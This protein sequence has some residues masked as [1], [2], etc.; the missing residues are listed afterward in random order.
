[1]EKLRIPYDFKKPL[2]NTTANEELKDE[3]GLLNREVG[4][5]PE[6]IPEIFIGQ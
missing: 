5:A 4:A 1:M 3:K 6:R 2:K